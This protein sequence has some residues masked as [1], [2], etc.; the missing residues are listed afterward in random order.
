M[1]DIQDLD[2]S[3]NLLNAILWQYNTGENL[4]ALLTSKQDWYSKNQT[5]FFQ[6]WYDNVFNLETVNQFG[7]KVWSIILGLPLHVNE[8]NNEKEK[9]G[10]SFFADIV[11]FNRGTFFQGTS[12][13][14]SV[15][16]QRILLQLR[17]FKLVSS[18]AIPE[19]NKFL[20][21]VF[22][23][24]SGYAYLLDGLDMSVNFVYN[25][26]ATSVLLNWI[27]EFDLIPRNSGVLMNYT[28]IQVDH[29]GFG[30]NHLNFTR[31]QFDPRATNQFIL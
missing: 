25:F 5:D 19:V 21:Y 6:G 12:L 31:G 23:N 29:F 1:S 22:R 27:M 24:Y 28:N 2:Y 14:L 20:D 4:E 15:D 9:F 11:N 26:D 10:F 3:V 18:G 13:G 17:Y 16:E 7:L 30:G 8:F